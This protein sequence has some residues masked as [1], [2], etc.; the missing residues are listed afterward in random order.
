MFLGDVKYKSIAVLQR[1]SSVSRDYLQRFRCPRIRIQ[2]RK[3]TTLLRSFQYNLSLHMKSSGLRSG[4]GMAVPQVDK[5]RDVSR[6]FKAQK[7][8]RQGNVSG[9]FFVDKTC[10][11]CDTCRWMAPSTFARV[12]NG[13][14]VIHQPETREERIQAIQ[15]T[16]SC[17]TC[18]SIICCVVR[19]PVKAEPLA[20][21]TVILECIL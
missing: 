18:V 7:E 13:S 16:L 3:R 19:L 1:S 6:R 21:L 4:R 11:D 10:I 15:A 8:P 9:Q 20:Y 2:S 14:A 12:G 5:P 17:P